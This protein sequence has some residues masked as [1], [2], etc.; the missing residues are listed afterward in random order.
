[1]YP[2]ADMILRDD[3]R[4][5]V[6]LVSS[7][8]AKGKQEKRGIRIESKWRL[9]RDNQTVNFVSGTLITRARKEHLMPFEIP[10]RH[11]RAIRK[12]G[13]KVFNVK[14]FRGLKLYNSMT[15]STLIHA[16]RKTTSQIED[17]TKGEVKLFINNQDAEL[18]RLQRNDTHLTTKT[19]S[20]EESRNKSE[21]KVTIPQIIRS[22]YENSLSIRHEYVQLIDQA[23]TGFAAIK[24]LL[25]LR[26]R[27]LDQELL[28]YVW[29]SVHRKRESPLEVDSLS[30]GLEE[31]LNE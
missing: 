26:K 25:T 3:L 31:L 21:L 10:D 6:I 2:D 22:A 1:M 12:L 8:L 5:E 14:P 18:W 11:M 4:H 20:P 7:T 9:N 29:S 19:V 13:A 16:E 27:G 24:R 23:I 28:D 30:K 15:D 17:E